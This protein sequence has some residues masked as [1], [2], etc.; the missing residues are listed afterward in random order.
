MPMPIRH[1]LE[2]LLIGMEVELHS[3]VHTPSM[4][5]KRGRIVERLG[6]GDYLVSHEG[7]AAQVARGNLRPVSC[8]YCGADLYVMKK[9]LV[10]EEEERLA[11]QDDV[12]R[13]RRIA[14]QHASDAAAMRE[15][16]HRMHAELED[17]RHAAGRR[18]HGIESR[19]EDLLA[20]RIGGSAAEAEE[21]AAALSAQHAAESEHRAQKAERS[22]DAT[23]VTLDAAGEA[24]YAGVQA[25]RSVHDKLGAAYTLVDKLC[26]RGPDRAAVSAISDLLSQSLVQNESLHDW[27]AQ[28]C[29]LAGR[30]RPAALPAAPTAL[31]PGSA[32]DS[33]AAQSAHTL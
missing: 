11:L 21:A 9:M 5:H 30:P 8:S 25:A 2:E 4:N 26:P 20:A 28:V 17:L 33:G 7:V 32:A 18:A 3:M 10:R 27:S 19:F 14:E 24:G 13:L 22:R 6:G 31:P 15:E 23:K 29:E 12:T 16:M 1:E